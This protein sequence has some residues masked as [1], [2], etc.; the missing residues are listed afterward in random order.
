MISLNGITLPDDLYIDEF[1]DMAYRQSVRYTLGGKPIIETQSL[2]N[3]VEIVV[4]GEE[5]S[6]WIKYSVLQALKDDVRSNYNNVLQLIFNTKQYNVMYAMPKP[7]DFTPLI[8]KPTY[9]D[10][11]YF[12]GSINLIKI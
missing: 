1:D 2:L 8:Q 9:N 6:G 3:G 10:N 11:D 5:D 12:Y 4:F 7:L